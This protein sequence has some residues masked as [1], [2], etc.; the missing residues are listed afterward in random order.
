LLLSVAGVCL[1]ASTVE[2][3]T[4]RQMVQRADRIFVGQVTAVRSYWTG[5]SIHTDVTFRSTQTVKGPDGP[6]V[7]LTFLGGTVDDVTLEVAGMP[8]FA[9]GDEQ[10]LFATDRPGQVSPLV[11]VW[12]G[13]VLISRDP[14]TRAARVLRHDRTPFDRAAAVTE[15][16]VE[17]S[18]TMIVPMNLDAFLDQVRQIASEVRQ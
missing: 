18:A 1:V 8:Q 15:R 12:H 17:T 7:L 2:P 11:G 10:V 3:P 5:A 6:L 9:V 16:A 14:R 4:L 13:R